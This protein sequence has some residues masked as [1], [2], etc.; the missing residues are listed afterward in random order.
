MDVGIGLLALT[1]EEL[2]QSS[3]HLVSAVLIIKLSLNAAQCYNIRSQ[4]LGRHHMLPLQ[5]CDLIVHLLRPEQLGIL[6][7]LP[8]QIPI[9]QHIL[10]LIE[11]R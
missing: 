5:I 6:L 10:A 3:D 8:K 11:L 1:T 7:Y 4:F 9:R 2:D